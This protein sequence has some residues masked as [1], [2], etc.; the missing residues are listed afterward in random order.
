MIPDNFRAVFRNRKGNGGVE[1]RHTVTAWN[2]LSTNSV[3][4]GSSENRLRE[5]CAASGLVDRNGVTAA[6]AL[7]HLQLARG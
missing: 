2:K 5:R 3:L 6:V 4:L 7:K 1:I